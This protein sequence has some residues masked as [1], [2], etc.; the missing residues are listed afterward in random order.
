MNT[1]FIGAGTES[2]VTE[3]PG[4]TTEIQRRIRACWMRV[5]KYSTQLYDRPTAAIPLKTRMAKAEAIEA[6]LYGSTTWTPRQGDYGQ[7]RTTHHRI[8][9]RILGEAGSVRAD[10]RVRSYASALQRTGCE[11]IETTLRKRRLLFAGAL[12]R[13]DNGRLPKRL[14]SGRLEGAAKR[15]RGARE[16]TWLDEVEKDVK[17]FDITGDWRQRA[18]QA[19]EWHAT[20]T[21]GAQTFMD[22]WRACNQQNAF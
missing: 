17:A 3:A 22:R 14:M 10:H 9:L 7:L 15:G 4:V 11:S 13:M 1:V 20:V 2:T 5:K 19:P 12:I 16:K 6:L 18:T 8:L 21:E